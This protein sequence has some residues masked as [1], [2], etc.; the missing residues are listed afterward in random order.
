VTPAEA[1]RLIL[2]MPETTAAPH[3]DREAFR[4]GGTIFATLRGD[5]V[6]NV[7]LAPEMQDVLCA[8]EP[9]MF[10]PVA[11]GWGRMGWTTIDIAKAGETEMRSALQAA[12]TLSREKKQKGRRSGAKR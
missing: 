4:A 7:K 6:L 8:A 1:R 11:G 9:D 3:V 2:A 12:W 5:G 10:K